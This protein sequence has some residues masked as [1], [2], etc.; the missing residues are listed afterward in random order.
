MINRIKPLIIVLSIAITLF[1]CEKE[2]KLA[3]TIEFK[4]GPGYTFEETMLAVG[5][6]VTVGI[7]A[8]T[9]STVNITNFNITVNDQLVYDEGYNV[10]GL[11]IDFTI[12][13]GISDEESWVFTVKDK[14]G[15][16][17]SVSLLLTKDPDSGFK[18]ILS[19]NSI[20]LGA[21]ENTSVG[22]FMSFSENTV[23]NLQS[24]YNNQSSI[25]MVYYYFED[26]KNVITS[27][28]ANIDEEVFD[29]SIAPLAWSVKR[30]TRYLKTSLSLND[31]ETATDDSLLIASYDESS[32]K[33]KAKDLSKDDIYSFKTEDGKLGLFLVRSVTGKEDGTIE[34]AVKIQE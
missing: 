31:Y 11:E 23:Y 9:N 1:S 29:S 26:D 28:G 13:K 5:D 14:D 16:T 27:P 25:D 7:I 22:G 3:P 2:N 30:T 34:I 20:S 6:S 19:Y 15:N 12:G 4:T 8:N 33:R 10:V 24:A 18:P 21:Q 32:A 17:A